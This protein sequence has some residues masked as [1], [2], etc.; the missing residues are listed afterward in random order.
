MPR[1]VNDNLFG[2]L[3]DS[4]VVDPDLIENGLRSKQF[5]TVVDLL[6]FGEIE[7]I[8]N[9]EEGSDKFRQNIFLDGTPLQSP[10]GEENFK[11][12]DVFLRNGTDDQRPIREI[13]AI[14]NTKP[15]GVEVTH[16]A[17][18]TRSITESSVDKIR[19]TLQ[20]PVLQF[21][22]KKNK[23]EGAEVRINIK[24]TTATGNIHT[25][26]HDEKIIGKASS[27][28][29]QDFEI[30][31]DNRIRAS[32]FP[33]S[34]TVERITADSTDQLL[35]NKTIWHSLT[36]INTDTKAYEG[37]AYVAT[38][39]NA[40]AFQNYPQR[41]YR[42]KGT[43]IKIPSGTSV[44]ANNGRI[45]YPDNYQFNGTFKTNDDGSI[46][47]EWCSDPAWVLYDI[48]TTDKGFGG[49]NGV[50]DE[51]NLDVFSFFAASA[52]SS[53]LIKD[54]ITNTT[55]PRFSTNVILNQKNDAFNLITDLCSVM[56]AVAFVSNEGLQISQ[57]RPTNKITG[58]SDPQYIFN[59][60]NVTE[61][62]FTYQ[63]TGQRT[64]YTEVEVGYFN[65]DTQEID[66]ELITTGQITSLSNAISKFGK[67]RKTLQA[68][69]CT[70][71]GQA[72]RLGRWFLYSNLRESETVSFTATLEAGV[73]IRPS[74]I[75]AIADSLRAGVR[76]GGRIAGV[77]SNLQSNQI[78]IIEVDNAID[79]DLTD[80]NEAFISVVMPDGSVE[81]SKILDIDHP[82]T[83]AFNLPLL[84]NRVVVETPFS[85]APEINSV[86]AI[87]NT[88]VEFQIYRV[89]SIEEK[90]R[91]QFKITAVVHDTDK[92]KQVE[93]N[94]QPEAPRKISTLL[95]A[96][97]APKNVRATEQIVA[98][99]NRVVSNI[100]LTFDPVRNVKDYLVEYRFNND[101]IERIK[102]SKPYFELL[103]TDAGTYTFAIKSYNALGKLSALTTNF[104][105]TAIGKLA[106][107]ADVKNLTIEPIDDKNVRLRFDQSKD[108]DVVHGGTVLIHYALNSTGTA[109]FSKSNFLKS[110]AGNSTEAI[111]PNIAEGEYIL[112]FVDDGG[113]RSFGETS[114]IVNR[115][116]ESQLELFEDRE[117]TKTPKF[118]G[119]K[120]NCVFDATLG[121]LK[122]TATEGFYLFENSLDLVKKQPLKLKNILVTSNF[123]PDSK[124]SARTLNVDE[125][126][127]FDGS[128]DKAIETNAK[129]LVATT[130]ED[131][132]ATTAN[133]YGMSTGLTEINKTN[134]GL[135]AGDLVFITFT[136]GLAQ[137]KNVDHDYLVHGLGFRSST[138]K[139]DDPDKFVITTP[140]PEI[141]NIIFASGNCNVSNKFTAFNEFV[142]S[143]YIARGFKFKCIF[144]ITDPAQNILITELG[145]RSGLA[146]RTE[147][148]LTNPLSTNGKFTSP[149]NTGKSVT[150]VDEFFT[151]EAG[152]EFPANSVKPTVGIIIENA[153]AGDFFELPTITGTG[154][155]VNIK[156]RDTSGN[157]SFV[158][159]NFTY[160]AIGFGRTV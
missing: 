116:R 130:D 92:Y 106:H 10:R 137:N 24:I 127:D 7:G 59:N 150:F 73:L 32:S 30:V 74:T 81:K 89:I 72:N 131:P 88:D 139:F 52:Y 9:P 1:L 85:V 43:K 144:Q 113:R 71:R 110:V 119:F 149:Q 64:K 45:I 78:N 129:V 69:A 18:V 16:A 29:F 122:A 104:T 132:D 118:D 108:V 126:F 15:V 17:S 153:Q 62:G 86:W 44:D 148:S 159:R 33:L 154:F 12:V 117:E 133:T 84:L 22:N 80:Q 25:P 90:D 66:F 99:D 160:T 143:E 65:N 157:V 34:V 26:V 109:D 142:N 38:R 95:D 42:V 96:A 55:E 51:D 35:Q 2:R 135:K 41:M 114:I 54:P 101:N 146:V 60:S 68:F 98:L 53:E 50:I 158:S 49:P 112:K 23:I 138:G 107:P 121:G 141:G 19:V 67:T 102:I 27:P 20:L 145:Y 77:H 37:F 97:E 31:F 82:S 48:L 147:T 87:E 4:R 105:F 14:E 124:L 83:N 58:T 39:F 28:Y 46:V 76:R 11:D 93:D 100:Q 75:I 115:P 140:Q 91:F 79:T 57:D 47:K 56:N 156:N 152:T 94:S 123:Y 125:W 128:D 151:G 134:H 136:S 21:I 155:T 61:D 111:V 36:E 103:E 63:G 120:K 40:Q 8:F 13:N 5:A 6:G 3:P 70:S